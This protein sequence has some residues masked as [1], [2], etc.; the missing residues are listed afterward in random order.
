MTTIEQFIKG[1]LGIAKDFYKR[2]KKELKKGKTVVEINKDDCPSS[3]LV[4]VL[5]R[6]MVAYY[7]VNLEAA[8]DHSKIL[9]ALGEEVKK[10]SK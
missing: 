3:R 7:Q 5:M 6:T 4:E 10:W 2:N 1:Q 8:K 9:K